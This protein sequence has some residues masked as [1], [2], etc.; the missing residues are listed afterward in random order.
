M[1]SRLE[2][3]TA[4]NV[5]LAVA[6][7]GLGERI[8]AWLADSVIL[9][10][11]VWMMVWLLSELEAGEAGF[12]LGV[13]LPVLLYHLL[14]EVFFE[15]QTPGKLAMKIRVARL[16]GA[17]P[18]LGQYALRWLLRFVDVTFTSGVGAV[19]SIAVTQRSQ[20]LG[21]LAAGTTVVRRRRRVRL[22]E[23]RYPTAP[24]GYQ[25]RFPGAEDL[26]DADVRTLRAVLVR[27]RIAGRRDAG[28]RRLAER[29]KEVVEKR[30]GLGR[31]AMPPQAF[32][33]TVVRDHTVLLD[34]YADGVSG[35][36][37]AEEAAPPR[38]AV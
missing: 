6:P 24:E 28:A 20:R 12:L 23:V 11:F 14:F 37:R 35:A 9:A 30:L 7:A 17:Q 16:D 34:R 2:I 10:G 13:V 1:E 26:S 22:A 21:D 29:A 19:L 4:Q 38:R 25:P 15:G 3:Q 32:L 31:V 5:A 18:T 27:T 33:V 8:L 36:L